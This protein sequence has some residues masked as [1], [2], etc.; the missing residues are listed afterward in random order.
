MDSTKNTYKDIDAYH[1]LQP[2]EFRDLLEQL[3]QTIKQVAP[4][5]TETISYGMPAF[6]Q[7][8]VLVY[9]ALNN[10]HLGF[11]PTPSAIEQF[12]KELE[13][14]KT[15]KGAIQF[16][17]DK[18]LPL[19]LIQDIVM[20]RMEEDAGLTKESILS[21]IVHDVPED[22]AHVLKTDSSLLERWNK[23]TPIQRNEWICWT[24][25]VKKPET[26]AAHIMRL[27][28][29]INDGQRQPCCWPGCPHRRPSAQK[30]F[31][32]RKDF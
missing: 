23:L 4:R 21:G 10:N 29:E 12:K 17:L 5:A 30:W 3:R 22:M 15:S 32:N 8:K 19:Q 1:A 31:K 25:S 6:K 26:R 13:A 11:Y 24:T 28:E 2:A 14:Y 9:Y 7:H 18:P 20:F 16:P 27:V